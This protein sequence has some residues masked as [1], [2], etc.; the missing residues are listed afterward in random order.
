[1]LAGGG[2]QLG[3]DQPVCCAWWHRRARHAT[4]T[5]PDDKAGG[6]AR[7]RSFAAKPFA[8]LASSFERAILLDAN[9]FFVP[10]E[11]L[12]H[13]HAYRSVGVQLFTDY[14]R[15]YHIVDPWL[16]SSYLGE[17]RADVEAYA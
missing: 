3:C 8:L 2:L 5:A 12:L 14:V 11:R 15:S 6:R 13:L 4:E 16:V 9:A 10:P 1:M 7:L 17:G